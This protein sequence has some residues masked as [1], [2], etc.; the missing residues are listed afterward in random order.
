[1]KQLLFV[2]LMMT[3]SVSW[4]EWELTQLNDTEVMYHDKS[5]I[6]RNSAIARMWTMT[7]FLEKQLESGKPY[8]SQITQFS[9]DCKSETAKLITTT[10][11]SGSKGQGVVVSSYFDKDNLQSWNPVVPG[12]LG[13]HEW[14]IACGKK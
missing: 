5:T 3:C 12:S 1:M 7:D 14:K 6:R 4:A 10:I 13:E 11:Y 8:K 9:Y 2:L